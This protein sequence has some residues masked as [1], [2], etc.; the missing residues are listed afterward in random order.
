MPD[1]SA[2]AKKHHLDR[3]FYPKS[4][5]VVGTT[6]VAGT[7]PYDIFANIV[8]DKFQGPVYPVSPGSR[9]ID[10]FKT[11]KYM[12]DISDPIDLAVVVFPSSVCHL[13]LEQCGEMG[14]K[15]AIVIS[16]GFREVG[17]EGLK[18]EQR[19]KAIADKYGM[20]FLGPNCLGVINTDPSVRLDASF[21]R[22]MPIE[23]RIAFLSQSGALC[24][25][26]LDFAQARQI[27]FSKFVS[28]GNKADVSEI[29]LLDYLK[30]DPKTAV[31]LVYLEEVRDG[32]AL[33]A[34]AQAVIR[35]SGKPILL[36]KSGRTRPGAAA[37]ASHTGS[38][39]GSDEVC[40]AALKQAGII[41]CRSIQ[42]M[43][44]TAIAMVYQPLPRGNRVAIVT[45]AGGPGVMATD[46]AIDDG[47]VLAK[48]SDETTARFRRS[49]PTTANIKNPVDVIGD[50][51]ADRYQVALGAAIADPGVDGAMVIVTPQS[52]TDLEAIAEAVSQ[53]AHLDA[54]KPVYASFMGEADAA[55][56]IEIL[57]R[58]QVPHYAQPESMCR[59]FAAAYRVGV[60][61]GAKHAPPVTFNDVDP[62]KARAILTA[63]ARAGRTHLPQ[64]EAEKVLAAY[65]LPLLKSR[66]AASAET[67][68]EA[69]AGLGYP[70]VMK[71]ICDDIVHKVD[72]GGV[73]LGIDTDE[74][75]R[76]AYGSILSRVAARCP[77]ARI[78]GVLVQPMIQGAEEVILGLK[79]DAS[80]GP[81][82]LFGLGGTFVEILRDVS[83]GIAPVPAD[84]V[85]AMI[86][87]TRAYPKLAGARGQKPRDIAGVEACIER[88]SQLGVDCPQIKELDVNPLLVLA[89]G[90]GCFVADARIML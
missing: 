76:A 11:Y 72:V 35:E 83:F 1:P 61:R 33:M 28:F 24:T 7:V 48:F 78:D 80:F 36:I 8:R 56:G 32:P 55:C 26:V 5:A 79:R 12:K 20:S 71:V 52:M 85:G 42:E 58:R 68:V 86:R 21:A 60:L 51:R 10:C 13:A 2:P 43:F 17:E 63:A 4:V 34:A 50:A 40:D 46:A 29:D 81:V 62:A 47:L 53:Q 70:V 41:R 3:I 69:A 49:L 23:G 54:G 27:G 66:T 16:A 75:A 31:I 73:V 84:R 25:A 9:V 82:V 88:L 44:D 14:V 22:K 57:Q 65:G 74:A 64:V 38:L 59:S 45:N 18:R 67:A 37:A 19:L 77:G 87:E 6:S 15:A 39:A 90:E 30:D 89:A